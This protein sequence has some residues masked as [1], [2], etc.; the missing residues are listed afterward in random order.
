MFITT[1]LTIFVLVKKL[2]KYILKSFIVPFLATFLIIL[3]VLVMQMLWLAF[4]DFAGKGIGFLFILKFLWYTTLIVAPQALPIGILL[5]SIMTLGSLSENYE[6]AAAKS[7]GVSL[8]RMVRPLVFFALFVSSINF[9]FLNYVYPYAILKQ[10]NLKLNIKKKQ[11]ALALVPGSFNADIPNYQIKFDEKYGEEDNLLKNVLIYDLSSTKGNTKVISA[12]KGELVSEEGSRYMTLILRDGHYFQQHI[13]IKNNTKEEKEK[14]PAS[15][16]DFDEY[17]INIDMSSFTDDSLDDLKYTKNF[18]MLSLNQLKDTLPTLKFNYDEYVKTRAKNLFLNVKAKDLYK[19]SDSILKINADLSPDI[20][21]NFK[22]KQKKLIAGNALNKVDRTLNNINSNKNTFKYKRKVLN[23]YDIEF[24]NRVAFSLSCL[25]L[26]FIGAPLGSIIRKGGMGLPMILAIAIYVTYFFTNTF[27]RNLAEESSVTAVLG[28]WIAIIIMLPLAI[29]LTVRAT[30]DKGLFDLTSF[31]S[32]ISK[33]I[34]N[35]EISQNEF[36]NLVEFH[37][38]NY[39]RSSKVALFI[40]L[41]SFIISPFNT[42]TAI[43]AIIIYIIFILNLIKTLNH[44]ENIHRTINLHTN[45]NLV[46]ITL[47]LLS[48]LYIIVYFYTIKD[49]K[50]KISQN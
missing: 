21:D 46:T 38:E 49:L 22:L 15:Y 25:L 9:I 32:R 37:F 4:D 44:Y 10:I 24:Y 8:Q 35:K 27:G 31:F 23:L 33:L 28:S 36:P 45:I 34:F 50:Q 19:Y 11:P 17:T 1:N 14:M 39:K 3:F 12:K 2:D 5:S 13:K 20:L 42:I 29:I 6:F 18:N 43:L 47:V 30:Q 41:F 48:P 16:A 7:A 40:Y 26:F